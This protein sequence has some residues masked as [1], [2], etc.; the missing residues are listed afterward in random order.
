LLGLCEQ[1][2]VSAIQSQL[3]LPAGDRD[4]L[5]LPWEA[6]H[7]DQFEDDLEKYEHMHELAALFF[8]AKHHHQDRPVF[9]KH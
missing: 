3:F 5:L 4:R 9:A 8:A 1:L 7:P 6:A 2:P